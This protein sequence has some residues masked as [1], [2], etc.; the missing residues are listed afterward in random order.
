MA[1]K[2]FLSDILVDGKIQADYAVFPA[3]TT[4]PSTSAEA[5]YATSGNL[6][7]QSGQHLY[8][9]ADE[10][11]SGTGNVYAYSGGS[12]LGA[13]Y[14]PNAVNSIGGIGLEVYGYTKADTLILDNFE[15]TDCTTQGQIVFDVNDTS[16]P[17]SLGGF[18]DNP[19]GLYVHDGN[20]VKRIW[21]TDN[22]DGTEVS[23]WETAY[24]WGDHSVAGYLTDAPSDGSEY[25]RLN[26]AWAVASGG[27][28][29]V[30]T[31]QS[32][33]TRGN[34]TTTSIEVQNDIYAIDNIAI[35][36]NSALARLDIQETVAATDS[37]IRL[38]NS[39]NGTSL[40]N[41]L[42]ILLHGTNAPTYTS[43]TPNSG[44]VTFEASSA[45][46]A[47]RFVHRNSSIAATIAPSYVES[48]G[49]KHPI[50][51]ATE[52]LIADG[53]RKS[54]SELVG[55]FQVSDTGVTV[56]AQTTTATYTVV[57]GS[58]W[59]TPSIN[60]SGYYTWDGANGTLRAD[61]DGV[62]E[63]NANI[64][65][66]QDVGANRTQMEIIIVKNGST[67]LV[68][69]SNYSHRNLTQDKGSVGIFSFLDEATNGDTYEV[70]V[71]DVGTAVIIGHAN[72]AKHTYISA[73][74]WVD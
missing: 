71:R 70:Q 1:S 53:S 35:G 24:G 65:A 8:N 18:T 26:G 44:D 10:D 56:N 12:I 20:D 50:G 7:M 25:V 17:A 5:I 41:G 69:A 51:T 72:V 28:T 2:T 38:G 29:E 33:T 54:I 68:G 43:T 47:F 15:E 42:Q 49:F 9:R 55:Y 63:I 73:K 39:D 4:A 61:K 64:T 6:Y 46:A 21:T 14:G 66:F 27:G 36:K 30:D 34:V 11:G 58:L 60:T 57:K 22:F 19:I 31:L 13:F 74:M 3:N 59:D 52:V 32:V 67:T 16:A 37:I 48:S 62:I 40:T 45:T 23:N